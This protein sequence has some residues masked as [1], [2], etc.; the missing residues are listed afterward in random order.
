M[1]QPVTVQPL[2]NP[3]LALIVD[4][5][6]DT[7]AMYAEYLRFAHY[8]I[9]EAADG[10]EGLAKAIARQPNIIVT[11]TRLPGIDGFALCRLLREDVLTR[12][13]PIL[14]VTG[15]G[16]AADTQRARDAG[17]TQVLVKPCLP[18]VLLQE[19]HRLLETSVALRERSEAARSK[20]DE[21]V[22]RSLQTFDRINRARRTLARSHD[23]RQTMTPPERTS[24]RCSSDRRIG[25]SA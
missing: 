10:R 6:D 5:D 15:D 11:E 23:R 20:A 9:E 18:E 16:Y 22:A 25:R 13:I 14:V 4:R 1:L 17:A 3:A 24:M 2:D 19:I 21:E 8:A 7:R 12:T